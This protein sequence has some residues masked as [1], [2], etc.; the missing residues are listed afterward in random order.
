MRTR[1]YIIF[2]TLLA[3]ALSA[4]VRS[5]NWESYTLNYDEGATVFKLDRIE[6]L[7]L[8]EEYLTLQHMSAEKVL[9]ST[10]LDMANDIYHS[11][12]G[13]FVLAKLW[14]GAFDEPVVKNLRA[15]S[16]LWSILTVPIIGLI[17]LRFGKMHAIFAVLIALLHPMLQYHGTYVRF[18]SLF[19]FVSAVGIAM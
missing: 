11:F 6:A 5:Y 18:Y 14:I 8:I 4:I 13:Y 9:A 10:S 7:P 19:V 16:L 3:C 1:N 15:F 2:F 12:P 17:A